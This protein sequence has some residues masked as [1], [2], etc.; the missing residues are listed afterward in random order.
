MYSFCTSITLFF[1]LNIILRDV[2][3]D[4]N[5]FIALSISSD[6]F[7]CQSFLAL[8]VLFNI[9]NHIII[10]NVI[11]IVSVVEDNFFITCIP[12]S[13]LLVIIEYL[14]NIDVDHLLFIVFM[15]SMTVLS[16]LNLL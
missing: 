2:I 9:V 3:D 16:Y 11:V 6:E 13:K 12:T 7:I 5:S 4:C 1:V 15:N 10:E 8:H 14:N